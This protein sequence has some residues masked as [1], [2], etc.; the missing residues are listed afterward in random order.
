MTTTSF[1]LDIDHCH[2]QFHLHHRETMHTCFPDSVG[3][4]ASTLCCLLIS[5][6]DFTPTPACTQLTSHCFQNNRVASTLSSTMMSFPRLPRTSVLSAPARRAS[7][8]LGLLSTVSSLN[9]CSRAVTSPVATYAYLL[10]N[11]ILKAHNYLG[12]WWQVHLR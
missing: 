6:C 1:E 3:G 11:N 9:S 5:S 4:S 8:M 7:D 10:I 12:H 2:H